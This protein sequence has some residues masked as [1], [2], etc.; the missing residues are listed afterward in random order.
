MTTEPNN[1]TKWTSGWK[2][3]A[4]FGNEIATTNI[5]REAPPTT[6]RRKNGEREKNTRSNN[7]EWTNNTNVIFTNDQQL[8]KLKLILLMFLLALALVLRPYRAGYNVWNCSFYVFPSIDYYVCYCCWWDWEALP[9]LHK[10][11][12]KTSSPIQ[13]WLS[14]LF[15]L[16]TPFFSLVM[17]GASIF[18]MKS[19]SQTVFNLH[20]FRWLVFIT[21]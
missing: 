15:D 2:K 11:R 9:R 20:C 1:H 21:L 6:N 16:F 3:I 18:P 4:L 17:D 7:A 10:R 5:L 13:F 8:T 19:K 12:N 14:V